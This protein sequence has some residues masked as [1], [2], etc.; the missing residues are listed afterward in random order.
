[1]L[2]HAQLQLYKTR[3]ELATALKSR[4]IQ[5]MSR[6][7][8][9]QQRVRFEAWLEQQGQSVDEVLVAPFNGRYGGVWLVFDLDGKYLDYF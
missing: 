8:S 3:L 6:L 1:V 4:Q 2:E 5:Y 9:R 7:D